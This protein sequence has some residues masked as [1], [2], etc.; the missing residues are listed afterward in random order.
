M[1]SPLCASTTDARRGSGFSSRLAPRPPHHG[2]RISAGSSA[3]AAARSPCRHRR[4]RT[5]TLPYRHVKTHEM[6]HFSVPSSTLRG[7]TDLDPLIVAVGDA[8]PLGTNRLRNE[9]LGTVNLVGGSVMGS[10]AARGDPRG[11]GRKA[12][13]CAGT[14]ARGVVPWFLGPTRGGTG[15]NASLAWRSRTDAGPRSQCAG[16]HA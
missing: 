8:V 16:P 14:R 3:F 13:A 11:G 15:E 10:T 6:R 2:T 1:L 12:R 7:R 9:K 5:P 4:P